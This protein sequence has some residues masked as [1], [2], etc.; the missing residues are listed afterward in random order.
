MC[1]VLSM[2]RVQLKYSSQDSIFGKTLIDSEHSLVQERYGIRQG[3]A[4]RHRLI[5]YHRMQCTRDCVHIF[6]MYT[7]LYISLAQ[8]RRTLCTQC[9]SQGT[10]L[11]QFVVVGTYSTKF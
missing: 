5:M 9:H 7:I 11:R 4:Y 10:N 2:I 8:D 3:R 1:V 6:Q